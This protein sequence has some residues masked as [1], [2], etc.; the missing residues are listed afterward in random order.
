MISTPDPL[1]ASPA[2]SNHPIPTFSLEDKYTQEDGRIL[3]SGIQA[4][5]RLVIDQHRA[6]QR[7]G[8]NTATL[9][10]GYRGSPLGSLDTTLH[11]QRRL[12]EQHHIQFIPAVNEELGA[13]AIFGSQ[14]ANLLPK[15]KY[16][17]VLG[18]WYGK[19]PGVDRSGDAFK[20]ANYAGVGRYG[21][22]LA[23]AGDDPT[24]KS[25][26]LPSHSEI[27]LYDAL[28]PILYPGSV[29]DILDLG[30]FGFELSRYSGLWVGFKIV[31]NVAD[32]IAT[33][34]VSP[35]RIVPQIPEFSYNGSPWKSQQSL[36]LLT[37][38]TNAIERELHEGR[39]EAAR[40]FATAN[41]INRVTVEP[42]EARVGLVAP[43]KTYY[44]MREALSQLGLTDDLL[45]QYGIRILKLG[46]LFPLD[47]AFLRRFASGLEEIIVLEEKRA[48]VELFLRDALYSLPDQPRIVGKRD[49]NN[50]AFVKPYGDL[51]SDSIKLLLISRLKKWIPD[52]TLPSAPDQSAPITVNSVPLLPRTPYFCSGCPHNTSTLLP[53]DS[54]AG[55]GIGC[56]TMALLM[57]RDTIGLTQMGGEG[58]QWIG[59][60][61][62]SETPHMFQNLGDG[63]LFHSGSLA[64]RQAVAANTPITYKI[65]YNSAVA[66]TGGQDADGAMSVPMLTHALKAEGVGKIIVTTPD[67][68]QYPLETRWPDD[69]EVWHRDR[70]DEAQRLL[71]DCAG[72]TVLIHDQEC[73]AELRRKRKRGLAVEP[74]TRIYINE[75]VCE[76]CGDCGVKSNCLSVFPVETEF[77]R[78]TQIHQS[79]CNK[80]Y[81]C[82]KGDC[83]A[84]LTIESTRDRPKPQPI[85]IATPLPDPVL[86]DQGEWNIYMMGI[87][88]TGVVTTNQII[89]T[90]AM[91]DGRFVRGLDQTGL[92]QKGGPV[93]SHLRILRENAEGAN[94]LSDGTADCYLVLDLLTAVDAANLT[95]A[96]TRRTRAVISTSQVPT[97]SMVA[98]TAVRFPNEHI[99]LRAVHSATRSEENVL[100]DA[101]TISE[102]LFGTTAPANL[103]MIG[104]AYQAGL[105]P[106]NAEAIERAIALNG[107]AVTLNT[108]AFQAGRR[109]VAEPEW[110]NTLSVR[111]PGELMEEAVLS[112][113]AKRL[114]QS[115]AV[116]GDVQRLLDVR[117]PELIA[118]QSIEYA[119]E[120]IA[121]VRQ[122]WEVEQ[123]K[124]PGQ[125][126]LTEAVA[127]YLFKLMAYK[128]E[129]EVARLHLKPALK[130]ALRK[131]FG[132]IPQYNYM[133][134]PPLLKAFGLKRKISLGRWFDAVYRLL[135]LLRHVRGTPL[136]IFGYAKLRR[137]ERALIQEYR[138]LIVRALDALSPDNYDRAVNLATL[139]DL[140]RGYEDVKLRNV[141]QYH[142]EVQRLGYS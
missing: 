1:T 63:T 30:R 29:Q 138:L 51:D 34:Q 37:P 5:V 129:Y 135:V 128:D 24:S 66:M 89:A 137:L 140:I 35:Q 111:R 87:G 85:S 124:M 123:A 105:L 141:E 11:Q 117:V 142:R 77:G 12:M 31:T 49:E 19:A 48:F 3:L 4:L 122:V 83:P 92:S 78:K 86:P 132:E 45:R 7:R 28:F 57:D 90:A 126:R 84:F 130:E 95:R 116:S 69:V 2:R 14:I 74:T 56:H 17:G 80:D 131:D 99:L 91:L 61:L 42:T 16:D 94:R 55:A 33:A 46:M 102:T 40:L 107:V 41:D 108:Q 104:A 118:Y 50:N 133:L 25:S 82:L 27:A 75:A 127:R 32:E 43:G 79:S 113:A 97:G 8:L 65:L 47:N 110:F 81:S 114:I 54:L 59:A 73:A 100:L 68:D 64:I 44:D 96:D 136:D 125:T 22:V 39:L 21:G 109:I 112:P 101:N 53:Q 134:H 6:D 120:Y 23:L 38:F 88:G 52:L 36:R 9:I 71:R 67:P 121:F 106:I 62:F 139:P 26:T 72:V 115:I 13:T 119:R 15:P 93:V 103:L 18:L 58:A 70:L 20:H 10:S 76:G 98:S 60:S